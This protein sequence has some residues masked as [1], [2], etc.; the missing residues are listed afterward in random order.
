MA[1]LSSHRELSSVAD[2]LS[3][4]FC[5]LSV[6]RLKVSWLKRTCIISL[7]LPYF[8]SFKEFSANFKPLFK[9]MNSSF[10]CT[11][12]TWQEL[13]LD[14]VRRLSVLLTTEYHTSYLVIPNKRMY[15][16]A[17]Y[18]KREKQ[19]LQVFP[20]L[21]PPNPHQNFSLFFADI[22]LSKILVVLSRFHQKL[23]T[24]IKIAG[25]GSYFLSNI[26]ILFS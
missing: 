25:T 18:Y 4:T 2:N 26:A 7:V 19:N 21:M 8:I 3:P 10:G 11:W 5:F 1:S 23:F 15:S 13:T 20:F 14:K 16:K 9:V 6:V 22:F 17:N 24:V 12:A